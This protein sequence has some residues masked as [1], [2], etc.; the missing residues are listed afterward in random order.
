MF[1]VV[2]EDEGFGHAKQPEFPDLKEARRIRKV[3]ISCGHRKVS[4]Y[5]RDGNK[6]KP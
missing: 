6:Q 5:D 4:I 1:K 2:I 3:A